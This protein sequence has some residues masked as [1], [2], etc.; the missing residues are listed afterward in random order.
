[1]LTQLLPILAPVFLCVALGYVWARLRQPF[2][3]RMV[4]TLVL[5]V[6]TPCLVVATLSRMRPD[7]AA[8]S[9]VTLAAAACFA[10]LIG[11]GYLITRLAG[12]PTRAYLPALFLTNN[13]NV[14]LPVCLFAFGDAGLALGIVYFVVSIVFQYT[15]GI[16]IISGRTQVRALLRMPAVWSLMEPIIRE[17]ETYPYARDMDSAGARHMWVEVTH[18]QYVAEDEQGNI[19]GTYYIKPNQP[20]LGAHVANCGYMVAESARGRGVATA[21]G[22]HSLD[23]ALRLGYRAMQFNLVV[24][25]NAA[26]VRVWEKLGFHIVGELSG[27]FQHPTQGY[28]DAYVMY[29]VLAD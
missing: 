5:N 3:T 26:S 18:T 28:V 19:L 22:R 10:V 29:K 1:M 25:T 14:G 9:A 16:A 21:M 23:E 13:G 7:P 17:G 15:V 20:T 24:M 8:L 27:A 6:T 12:I 4:A 11:A 2:D